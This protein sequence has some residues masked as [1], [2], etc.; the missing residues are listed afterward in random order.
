MSRMSLI[1][2]LAALSLGATPVLADP[3]V[4]VVKSGTIKSAK[5]SGC[6]WDFPLTGRK[7]LPDVYVKAWVY[8]KTGA[9]VDYGETGIQ[10]DTLEP[11]WE[12]DVV[13][14]KIGQRI[15]I[16][17]WDKDVK[18][19]DRIGG[20]DFWLT[21][22]MVHKRSFSRSFERVTDL[23][24]AIRTDS[25]TR[26]EQRVTLMQ[27]FPGP[28]SVKEMKRSRGRDR[29]VV[30]LH[31]LDLRDDG[32]A[33][34]S[35]RF[36]DWQGSTSVLVKNLARHADIFS[37]AYAQTAAVEEIATFH[38]LRESIDKVKKLGYRDIVLLG[39][40]AGGLVAR[41]FVEENPN[42]GVTRVIQVATPNG[43]AKLACLAVNLLQ[44]PKDQAK[45][46]ESLS[47]G[48]RESVLKSRQ[49]KSIPASID[50][51][52]VVACSSSKKNGDGAVNREC[53]WTPDL[54]DQG[55]PCVNVDGTH[56]NLIYCEECNDVFC[57]LVTE[58]QPRWS[59]SKVRQVASAGR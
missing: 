19:D 47:P 41:H 3:A 36:V 8:D 14:A 29:A 35:P 11:A 27:P 5:A 37:I 54:Q 6:A 53:Q 42:A 45:F 25:V 28:H 48:H 59:A 56:M 16:E 22:E 40:S 4:I 20:D 58:P 57:K 24:F 31:G 51:V 23:Q 9:Q 17:V 38:E 15:F 26:N 44:V 2:V 46:V 7:A 50:F 1:A 32:A 52:T 10:W 49:D 43:G 21:S 13:K 33:A 55:I 34:A 39:H 12:V 30:L 18:Y